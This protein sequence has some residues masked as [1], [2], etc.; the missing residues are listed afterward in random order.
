MN[1][2]GITLLLVILSHILY[3][4]VQDRCP[5]L[6]AHVSAK[7]FCKL[8]DVTE[9]YIPTCHISTLDQDAFRCLENTQYLNLH[10][11][12]IMSLP[13]GVFKD[14]HNLGLLCLEGM[15]ITASI[16]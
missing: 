3:G 9:V 11:N 12:E 6:Q 5:N 14:M 7:D 1:V 2:M 8:E 13:A 10:G 15:V 4:Q 16:D